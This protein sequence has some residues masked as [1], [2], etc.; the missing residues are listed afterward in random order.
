MK[1][2]SRDRCFPESLEIWRFLSWSDYVQIEV[3]LQRQLLPGARQRGRREPV[4]RTKAIKH[5]NNSLCVFKGWINQDVKIVYF[6]LGAKIFHGETTN[7]QESRI[8][9]QKCAHEI[10]V[11]AEGM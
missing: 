3:L 11:P 2:L 9:A 7:N 5:R 8:T 1:Q 6:S 4:T 10:D